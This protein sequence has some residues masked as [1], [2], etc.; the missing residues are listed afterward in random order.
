MELTD[1]DIVRVIREDIIMYN[2]QHRIIRCLENLGEKNLNKKK[3]FCDD[4]SF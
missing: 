2:R 4:E 3:D 1:T